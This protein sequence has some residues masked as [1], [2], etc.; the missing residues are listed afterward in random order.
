M[1]KK[2][3]TLLPHSQ[4]DPYVDELRQRLRAISES[5]TASNFSSLLDG[6]MLAALHVAFKLV[7]ASEGTVWLFSKEDSALIV[8]YNSGPNA[9]ALTGHFKLPAN[10]GSM[11]MVYA[12][13]QSLI[14]NEL[15]KDTNPDEIPASMSDQPRD[16]MIA[17]PFYFLNACRG[18][19]S[20]SQLRADGED[21]G[22]GFK[23]NDAA[24]MRTA[25]NV[26]GRLVEHKILQTTLGID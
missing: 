22:A 1:N 4:F 7:G 11:G 6:T 20:C 8:A 16:A 12:S 19:I 25:A 21:R 23:Q 10:S 26:L 24:T 3:L 17:T 9:E 5:I 15:E 2:R 14:E 13:E 18:V